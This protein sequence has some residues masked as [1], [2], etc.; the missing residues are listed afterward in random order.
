MELTPVEIH[1][2]QADRSHVL[3]VDDDPDL[4]S[5]MRMGFERQGFDVA[6]ATDGRAALKAFQ[7]R[8][9]D[10]VITDLI[11]PDM[12]GIETTRA[13]KALDPRVPIIAVSGGGSGGG[14]LFL[15][16]ADL[17]GA[18]VTVAKPFRMVDLIS[19]AARLLATRQAVAA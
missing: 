18:D 4:L 10:L 6:T 2:P 16:V 14:G 8:A 17:I 13:M 12:E 1:V 3:I 15:S 7:A 9:P 5:V 11:M 19:I